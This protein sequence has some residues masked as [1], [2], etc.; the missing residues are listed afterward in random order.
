M[1]ALDC[2][3]NSSYVRLGKVASNPVSAMAWDKSLFPES[4]LFVLP[5]YKKVGL[6]GKLET[7]DVF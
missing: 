2:Y 5:I 3:D 1:W 6:N 4:L 7:L